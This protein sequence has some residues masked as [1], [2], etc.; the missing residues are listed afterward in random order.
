LCHLQKKDLPRASE[1]VDDGLRFNPDDYKLR[2]A[3][4]MVLALTGRRG[5]AMNELRD[6][7]KDESESHHLE[8][9]VLLGTSLGN[10]DE[11]FG[12]LMRQWTE[13]HSGWFLI[14]FDPLFEG[15]WKDPRFPEFCKKA[16]LPP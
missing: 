15:L 12:A 8:A 11:A 7:M 16:G 6:L 10:L 13:I 4:G 1:A 9:Q 14:Q 2:E 5:E 3:Q